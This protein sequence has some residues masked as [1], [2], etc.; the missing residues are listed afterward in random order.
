MSDPWGRDHLLDR[1]I[2]RIAG[3]GTMAGRAVTMWNPPGT[4]TMTRFGIEACVPGDVLVITT[5]TDGTAQWGDL[6]HDW[7]TARGLAGVVID[8]SVRD[9]DHVST[10]ELPLWAR[11]IDPRQA[12]KTAHGYVNAPIK[13]AGVRICPGDLV[14]ADSDGIVIVP[15]EDID[16]ALELALKRDAVEA[17]S[18]KDLVQA[19]ISP[20]L[21]NIFDPDG[22][23]FVS[24]TWLDS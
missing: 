3:K 14:V 4:N 18:R 20:H 24:G 23:E 2:K 6:A 22:V 17:E 10:M 19:R 21:A 5:P 13:A 15:I 9:V 11:S 1:E 12:L 7:A 16:R 8:G